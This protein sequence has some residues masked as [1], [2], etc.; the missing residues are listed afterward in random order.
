LDCRGRFYKKVL[1]LSSK[2]TDRKADMSHNIA[3]LPKGVQNFEELRNGGY[4]YV[5]KSDM[6][7]SIANGDKFNFLSRPRR[8]GKSL[9]TSTLHYYFEG[10]KDLFKGL[11]IMDIEKEWPRRQVFHFDFSGKNTAEELKNHLDFRLGN[12][13][14]NQFFATKKVTVVSAVT[15]LI[16]LI[17]ICL[18]WC[19]FD[20]Y[21]CFIS[22]L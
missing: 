1:L 19:L 20:F 5:D 10:R 14:I 7:W 13:T 3:L 22:V 15:F 16:V 18:F 9:L 11:K 6:V 21:F 8:F 4:H 17:F 12:L 2:T